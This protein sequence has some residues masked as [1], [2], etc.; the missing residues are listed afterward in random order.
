MSQEETWI[1]GLQISSML[2][3]EKEL[4]LEGRAPCNGLW[5]GEMNLRKLHCLKTWEGIVPKSAL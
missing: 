4:K 3:L 2:K 1:D 5:E